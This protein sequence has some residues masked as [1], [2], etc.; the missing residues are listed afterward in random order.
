M[1]FNSYEFL[2]FFLP[3]V[4]VGY[5]ALGGYRLASRL[6]GNDRL[7]IAFLVA[8]SFFF[9]AW[10]RAEY[11]WLLAVSI[12]VNYS[13]GRAIVRGASRQA[14]TQI[15]LVLGIAFDLILL[16]Y[17]KY[18]NFFLDNVASLAGA[19]PLHLDVILP[20]GISFFT[21]TQIAFLVDA[22][23]GKAA[24]P[25]PL[26]Y[27]LFVT[28]FPHLL[29]GPILHHRE[30]MPQFADPTTKRVDWD[31]VARGLVLLA[32]GL[33]KKVLIADT[34]ALQA[35]DAF[36]S[37]HPITFGD[38]W[39]GILCYTLQIY[40]DFSGYTDMAL[41]MALMMN[42][43]LPQNFDSP[44]R[45]RNL[46]EF[47]R[48]WHMTLTRFLRDYVYIPIG[49]NRHGEAWT[50]CAIVITFLLGGLW[51]GANWT[52]VIWG[53][54]NGLGLVLLRAWGAVGVRLPG[55]LAWLVTF[56]FVNIAWVFFRAPDL[57]TAGWYLAAL[58]GSGG[59]EGFHLVAAPMTLA[60][61]AA[62]CVIAAWPRNSNRIA[63]EMSFGWKLQAAT[64]LLLAAGILSLSNPTD[65]LYFNF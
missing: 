36:G 27:S 12:A 39:L 65:F 42:I 43:R 3:A 19:V 40:F 61:L 62:A 25:D 47:W 5:F 28:Y 60:T 31:N 50:A 11:V 2:L 45:Q 7:A 10:W 33:G 44:Y 63:A 56:L 35:N 9:Y 54:M 21:F 30:M 64:A 6:H 22:A 34:L 8:A 29:A 53:L 58:R 55:F 46:Q 59:F 26:N 15:L 41:G 48:H 16:G 14:P 52:F 32:I 18:A 23:K 49:G 17:F 1:L 24:E 37:V 38:A 13:V 51:H 20:I 57:T 4:L